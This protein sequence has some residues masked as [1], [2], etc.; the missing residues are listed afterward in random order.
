MNQEQTTSNRG[1]QGQGIPP[2]NSVYRAPLLKWPGGKRSVVKLILEHVPA[3]FRT[4]YEPFFGGG[5]LFFAL[6]PDRAV[7]G[8]L[9]EEL[10]NCYQVVKNEPNALIEVIRTFKNDEATYYRIRN[11]KPRTI[12]RRAARL[13]YLTRLSF[14]GIHRVNLNG[15]FNVP[16]GRKTH[17]ASFDEDSIRDSSVALSNAR[18]V[19]GDFEV[20]TADASFGDLI[21]F[22]PPY[23]VAHA[24]NGFLKYNERIFSWADQLRLARHARSLACRGCTVIVSNADHES[25]RQLYDH[26]LTETIERFSVISASREHRRLI[27]E[28]LFVLSGEKRLA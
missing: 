9:N 27:T 21:Y 1:S 3:D 25:V 20:I 16:Y 26:A 22:D 23:T 17:L 5:A 8:D 14:N 10:V 2:D 12:I 15:D 4:Y 19:F 13:L 24:D 6:D 7:I 28:C 18:I 11:Y